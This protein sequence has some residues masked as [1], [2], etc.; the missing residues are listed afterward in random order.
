MSSS[1]KERE[2]A[3]NGVPTSD[4][5]EEREVKQTASNGTGAEGSTATAATAAP[6]SQQKQQLS[7]DSAPAEE[8]SQDHRP[9]TLAHIQ[10]NFGVMS[11]VLEREVFRRGLINSSVEEMYSAF[12][13]IS[14]V[15]IE[16]LKSETD[17]RL[18]HMQLLEMLLTILEP[19][20]GIDHARM[21]VA[22]MDQSVSDLYLFQ[23]LLSSSSL[24]ALVQRAEEFMNPP[25]RS[26]GAGM[27]GGIPGNYSGVQNENMRGVQPA[28]NSVSA[29]ARPSYAEFNKD[30]RVEPS[31]EPAMSRGANTYT[32]GGGAPASSQPEDDAMPAVASGWAAVQRKHT[33]LDRDV[34]VH[35]HH[36]H[37][38][39]QQ[40]QPQQQ[41]HIQ[42]RVPFNQY[43]HQQRNQ[44]PNVAH[45]HQVVVGTGP[46]G[47]QQQ[48]QQQQQQQESP[49]TDSFPRAPVPQGQQ[50]RMVERL[51]PGTQESD[52]PHVRGPLWRVPPAPSGTQQETVTVPQPSYHAQNPSSTPTPHS[53][54]HQA[55]SPNSPTHPRFLI[56]HRHA[57]TH[58]VPP[59][60]V[61]KQASPQPATQ[62]SPQ[63]P[64]HSAT[65]TTTTTATTAATA[66]ASITNSQRVMIPHH[67][68]HHHL[69]HH[70]IPPPQLMMPRVS[71][72]SQSV[73]AVKQEP[74]SPP[75]TKPVVHNAETAVP[76]LRPHHFH[77]IPPTQQKVL[78]QPQSVSVSASLGGGA[79]G[80]I[81]TGSGGGG[82][83][84]GGGFNG[85]GSEAPSHGV[86]IPTHHH[87]IH[88]FQ[89]IRPSVPPPQ[90]QYRQPT[91]SA[92]GP[93]SIDALSN[94]EINWASSQSAM[95][96]GPQELRYFL[97]E[98]GV[99]ET[100]INILAKIFFS[101]DELMAASREAF[102][103]R[104]KKEIVSVNNRQYIWT[105][106]H[107]SEKLPSEKDVPEMN[108]L[109]NFIHN[110]AIHNNMSQD[111]EDD[112]TTLKPGRPNKNI[113]QVPQPRTSQGKQQQQQQQSGKVGECKG[114]I[115]LSSVRS[116]QIQSAVEELSKYGKVLQHGAS[117]Q[118]PDLIYFKLGDHKSELQMMRKI[119]SA[120]VEDYYRVSPGDVDDGAPPT[121]TGRP[122]GADDNGPSKI[123]SQKAGSGMHAYHQHHQQPS[124]NRGGYGVVDEEDMDGDETR[125]FRKGTGVKHARGRGRGGH[126]NYHHHRHPEGGTQMVCRFFSK[127]TCKY[128]EHCQYFHPPK[129]ASR[130]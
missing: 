129:N 121:P 26:V 32:E 80:G 73:H 92:P 98:R 50:K 124:A 25:T 68:H 36:H 30:R 99:A 54:Q 71:P 115:W 126:H 2:A 84:G 45:H 61:G 130:S 63:K 47:L 53:N 18:L 7:G 66:S 83:G 95:L 31:A 24:E 86:M 87:M 108:E 33:D 110:N 11:R 103:E 27:S 44:A 52:E 70:D 114:V 59:G 113:L 104:I 128:G 60:P 58:F 109:R 46:M 75:E 107:P 91:T 69:H 77:H 5:A 112:T 72:P 22:I 49:Q 74:V 82:G 41:Q 85:G 38:Q 19:T 4:A 35:H 39:Q 15:L 34:T 90:Q 127:G 29:T 8:E 55:A 28:Y 106:L 125:N 94:D 105:I 100:V 117:S 67:H 12:F 122:E 23:A 78:R 21:L 81:S 3:E 118:R 37:Q 10:Q 62:I 42:H 64:P 51:P 16:I 79:G 119:G 1:E 56:H 57:T 43:L 101:L 102:E 116:W 97:R 123:L 76:Q 20:Y 6:L 17:Q 9:A 48:Q 40:Q 120:V 13:V 14:G 88:H 65:M 96:S 93:M 89:Q 111:G